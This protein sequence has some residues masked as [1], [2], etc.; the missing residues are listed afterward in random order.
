MRH[1]DRFRKR[2]METVGRG[3]TMLAPP[4][5]LGCGHHGGQRPRKMWHPQTCFCDFYDVFSML[6]LSSGGESIEK[7]KIG[8]IKTVY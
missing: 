2:T 7:L 4:L 6:Q 1:A 5:E 3:W 8:D